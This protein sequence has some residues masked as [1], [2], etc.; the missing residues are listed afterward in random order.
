MQ[1][2][3]S[4][5]PSNTSE[6]QNYS[7]SKMRGNVSKRHPKLV[8]KLKGCKISPTLVSTSH[9]NV[10]EKQRRGFLGSN[11]IKNGC[12]SHLTETTSYSKNKDSGP[13]TEIQVVLTTAVLRAQNFRA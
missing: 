2:I 5:R 11:V 7:F 13:D 4:L 1:D 8:C 10:S 6:I 9:T 12:T 3:S